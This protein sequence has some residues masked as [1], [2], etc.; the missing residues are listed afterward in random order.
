MQTSDISIA[1]PYID[2]VD[3]STASEN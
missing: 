3:N 1:A 2:M